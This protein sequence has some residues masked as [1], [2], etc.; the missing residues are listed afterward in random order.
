MQ[1]KGVRPPKDPYQ[2]TKK[3]AN[4][5]IAVRLED[6]DTGPLSVSL[7]VCLSFLTPSP[8]L[9]QAHTHTHT[10]TQLEQ[11]VRLSR[12]MALS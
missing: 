2:D 4:Q 3:R 9:F 8:S 12:Q 11:Y 7:S 10:H 6:K 5:L 1:W